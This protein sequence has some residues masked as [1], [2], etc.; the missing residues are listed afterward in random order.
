MADLPSNA[1]LRR[2][3]LHGA[4]QAAG[5]RM[6]PFAG[7]EMAL[8]F[9][10]LV[11]EHR[12]VRQDCGLF[13]I[14]HMGVISLRGDAVKDALQA[15]VPT[16]LHRIGPGEACYTVLLNEQGGVR[17]DLIVY[18]RGWISSSADNSP[19]ANN[20]QSANNSH[21]LLLVINAACAEEDTAWILSQLEAQGVTVADRKGDGVL[22]ALQ[23]PRAASRLE[24]LAGVSLA[25]LPRFGH[26][27][28][29]LAGRASGA[30]AAA[31]V[32][33]ARTGYT[34][35]DGF[36]LLL[37]REA[38][39]A[40]WQQLVAEGVAPCGLGARDSLRLEAAM[41]LYGHELDA[42]TTPLEA[43]LGWL[44][45]LEMPKPFIG[46]QVLERQSAEGPS[47]RLVGLKLRGRAIARHGYPVLADGKPVGVVT[48]G[49]WSPSLEEAIALAYVPAGLAKLGTALAVE[50][51][52][53]AEPAMVVSRP[54]Y[55]RG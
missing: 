29:R 26:R 43:G 32:F 53:K 2:T 39:I 1:L 27:E 5:G 13:D 15:L 47:R 30:A 9:A 54:F 34:G 7:W 22:L 44:V 12:A 51:R 35:E 14:S 10:G 6:V 20:S 40:L 31:Q 48:S 38:G 41:H 49:S 36:E 46:R 19:A 55:R 23:G 24:A 4:A 8:Q 52:G 18:D 37:E 28:L 17:D 21:E 11:A 33:V 50:I 45:H 16:D 3:P 42:S 25:N